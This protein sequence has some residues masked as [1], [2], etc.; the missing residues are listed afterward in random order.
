MSLA[1][2]SLIVAIDGG[3]GISREGEIPW[4]CKADSKFFRETT[5]GRGK[6]AV[7]MGRLTYESIPSEFRPLPNRSNIVVSRLWKQEDHTSI[8]VCNSLID[9]LF[10]AS[11]NKNYEEVFIIGGEK[12]YNECIRN[13]MYLCKKIYVTRFKMNYECD[14]FF[15]WDSVKN[16][17]Y[18]QEEQRSRDYVRYFLAPV[19]THDEYQY[20]NSLKKILEI[21]ENK[22]DRTGV[23]TISVFGDV[24]LEFDI[25][26]RI[27]IITTK[28]V[29]FENI[30]KELLFFIS[31][32]TDT[33][34]LERQGVNI[35]KGHTARAYLD[36]CG[37]DYDEGIA[38]PIYSFQW[39][40]WG[41]EYSG[42]DSE[43]YANKGIDQLTLIINNIKED[44][45]SRRHI[46]SAWN[47]S[48]LDKMCLLPC[49]TMAQFN[50]S[51]DG[52]YLD[53]LMYQRSG[54]FFLGV[55]Y[56]I[57]SYSMLTYM[58]AHLTNL[59]PRKFIHVI[60]DAHIYN[61]HV[62]QVNKQLSRTPRPFAKLS[63][64]GANK[65]KTIDDFSIDNFIIE[66]Y[67]SWDFI[68]AEMAV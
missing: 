41:A 16:Y 30:I 15:P 59:K 32:K 38:G 40:H 19:A 60:G 9:A 33:K 65:I 10:T 25:S 46:L 18:F 61:N 67:T 35:W 52:R 8:T 58:I 13:F 21:G 66:G 4:Q 11:T 3:N 12:I 63:F 17:N 28:K 37:L 43:D 50:V 54:D 45:H 22:T 47:V 14:Q 57:T 64:R 48:D 5:I 36:S 23:G 53:C 42:N 6:N 68:A 20:L 49:H 51:G 27:P 26:E 1:K 31:G 2:F 39:R 29:K 7:I 55:P 56:N 34:I 62:S 24:R 44:P